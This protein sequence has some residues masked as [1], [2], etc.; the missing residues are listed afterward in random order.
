MPLRIVFCTHQ[1]SEDNIAGLASGHH[2][3]P[4]SDLG[5]EQAAERR[6]EMRDQHFDAAFCSD[7][8]R[9][10]E[11]AAIVLDGRGIE[12]V[13]DAR[14]RELDYGELTRHPVPEVL[15]QA[16]E[17]VDVPYPGGE[18]YADATER[19]RSFLDETAARL[20]DARVLLIGHRATHHALEHLC[21]GRSLVD[22]VAA[23]FAWQPMWEFE[24][25]PGE[26]TD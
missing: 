10:A 23:E 5:R 6:E 22:A 17:H 21:D 7:L 18:S 16:L 9:A 15:G 8:V 13:P 14:L 4:L 24:Y 12:A 19:M 2:D 25:P 1:T 20:G 11:T 26:R 3:T